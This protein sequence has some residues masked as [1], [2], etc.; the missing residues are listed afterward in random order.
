MPLDVD[1]A[2]RYELRASG[3]T[4]DGADGLAHLG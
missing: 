4:P 2:H 1:P 3:L